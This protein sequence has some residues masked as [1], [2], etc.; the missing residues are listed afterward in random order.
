MVMISTLVTAVQEKLSEMAD[1][2]KTIREEEK[3]QKEKEAEGLPWWR[4]G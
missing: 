3:K 4:S 2:I 1:Q